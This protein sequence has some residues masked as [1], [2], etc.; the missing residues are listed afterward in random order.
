MKGKA[1]GYMKRNRKRDANEPEIISILEFAGV[2]VYPLDKPLDLLCGW[3]GET[4]IIEVKNP[5][6]ANRI[7]PDQKTFIAEWLGRPP[8]IIRTREQALA[9]FGFSD[10]GIQRLIRKYNRSQEK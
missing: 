2:S 5:N 1:Q 9:V 8:H 3:Q 7:E 4:E 10:E 6:G